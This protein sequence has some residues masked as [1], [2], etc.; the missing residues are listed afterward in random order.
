MVILRATITGLVL[1][2][3][4]GLPSAAAQDA[5]RSKAVHSTH[6]KKRVPTAS[7]PKMAGPRGPSDAERWMDRASGSGNGGGGY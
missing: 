4:M 1:A 7:Q 3:L 5:P 2:C 6:L